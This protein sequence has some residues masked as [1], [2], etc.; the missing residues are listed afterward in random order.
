[1]ERLDRQVTDAS[2]WHCQ[3][4]GVKILGLVLGTENAKVAL[5]TG[6]E[7]AY[8]QITVSM[9]LIIE[10]NEVMHVQNR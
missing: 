4:A 10:C 9:N 3:I 2:R 1:M 7:I 8:I 6:K 5:Y